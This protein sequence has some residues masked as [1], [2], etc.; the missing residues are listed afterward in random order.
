MFRP[1]PS[2]GKGVLC[3]L[4]LQNG[5]AAIRDGGDVCIGYVKSVDGLDSGGGELAGGGGFLDEKKVE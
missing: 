3:L 5:K 4:L 1:V 2:I